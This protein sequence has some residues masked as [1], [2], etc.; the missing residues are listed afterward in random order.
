MHQKLTPTLYIRLRKRVRVRKGKAI[1]LGQIAEL[2]TE[3]EYEAKIKDL[4]VF[5]PKRQDGN[6]VLVDMM[7]IV[8]LVKSVVPE[9]AV[10]YFGEPHT[11]VE[12]GEAPKRPNIVLFLLVWLLL[13]FGSGL[14]IMNFHADVSM[15]PVQQRIVELITGKKDEHPYLFQLAYSLGIGFGMIVF[16][17]HVFKKKFNEEPTPLE[18]EMFLYQ[19]NLNQ[20]V[21]TEEYCR[22]HEKG[23]RID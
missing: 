20:F 9:M 3:P 22:L 8:R 19:E 15:L 13:F 21:I 12:I 23:E 4:E 17:N 14:A 18:V 2:L 10:E 5:R 16:F 7:Q 1:I 6:I 11:L